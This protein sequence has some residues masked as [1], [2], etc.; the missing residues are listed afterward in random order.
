MNLVI[1]TGR[2]GIVVS[3]NLPDGTPVTRVSVAMNKYWKDKNGQRQERTTWIR[4][5]FWGKQ[6]EI[7]RHS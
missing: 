2:V 1:S 4:F 6:A 5:T 7:A 3:R